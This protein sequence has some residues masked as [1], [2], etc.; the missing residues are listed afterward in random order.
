MLLRIPSR[1]TPVSYSRGPSVSHQASTT[2]AL[3]LRQRDAGRVI[4][5]GQP[6]ANRREAPL[7]LASISVASLTAVLQAPHS[8]AR[9]DRHHRL[10][11]VAAVSEAAA[12]VREQCCSAA[13]AARAL[14][15][16]TGATTSRP[17]RVSG[18]GSQ[19]PQQQQQSG[20]SGARPAILEDPFR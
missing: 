16:A 11:A 7:S 20:C 19:Q 6:E 5:A 3:Q 17:A 13:A 14:P 15:I 18:S 4:A 9:E 12:G 10:I 2:P 8:L 1:S